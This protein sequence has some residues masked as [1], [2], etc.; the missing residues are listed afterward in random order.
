MSSLFLLGNGFDIAH[1]IPTK[2]SDFRTFIIKLYPEAFKFRD[3]IISLEELLDI[4]PDEFAAEILLNAMDKAAGKDWCNFED[5]LV[6]VDF[7]NK[8]PLPNHKD[9]ETSEEDQAL[10]RD[11]LL[12]MDVLTSGLIKCAKLW[13]EF[14][15]IWLKDIQMQIDNN[16]FG[17]KDV[18]TTLFSQPDAQFLTFNYTKTLQRL[19][20]IKKVVHIHNRVGQK[21]I[22]GHGRDNITYG[23]F[24]TE[25]S[26]GPYLSS[27]FLDDMIMSF[28][29][30]TMSP[31]K[32]YESFF[33]RLN[34]KI[35]KVYSY[36]FSYGK[37]DSVYIK[38]IIC[39][40]APDA[41]WL[42]SEFETQNPEALRIKK[43]K[44]RKYGF[45]GTFD[46]YIGC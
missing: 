9:N 23:Q 19:Y 29:K 2:Y 3:K 41:T 42:F 21:L 30:D 11:Y 13:Q 8:L 43:I 27:S 15:R 33:R 46:I 20:G 14:F 17:S 40:I 5:A 44:L 39:K 36:G 10:M 22:F 26:D 37:V 45:K 38:R 35:D 28:K 16:Q 12:Y 31:F 4:A 6:Y 32:K 1:G 18:L 7:N 25:F 24:S 34:N